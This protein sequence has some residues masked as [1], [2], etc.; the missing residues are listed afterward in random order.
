[1]VDRLQ[2]FKAD[3]IHIFTREVRCIMLKL[4]DL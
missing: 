3:V 4:H 2:M 1:M